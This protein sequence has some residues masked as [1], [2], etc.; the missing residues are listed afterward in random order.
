LAD[1]GSRVP[2]QAALPKGL[3]TLRGLEVL[4]LEWCGLAA[5]SE[6]I[7]GLAGLRKLDVSFNRELTALPDGLCALASLEEL[8]LRFCAGLITQG[9]PGVSWGSWDPF[10]TP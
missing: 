6:G 8:D 5:L 1:R 9:V 4:R 10:A 7:S 2:P 3:Y